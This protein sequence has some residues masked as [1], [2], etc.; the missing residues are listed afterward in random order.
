MG[1]SVTSLPDGRTVMIAGEHEDSYDPDFQIYNDVIVHHPDDTLDIYGYPEDIFPPT[2][3][4]TATLI[5]D[6]IVIIGNLGYSATRRPGITQV[7]ELDLATFAVRIR[8]TTGTPPG[9]LHQHQAV[10]DGDGSRIIV[11]GGLIDPGRDGDPGFLENPDSWSLDLNNWEWTRLTHFPWERYVLYAK[12]LWV[13]PLWNLG[14]LIWEVENGACMG[15]DDGDD[16]DADPQDAVPPEK[17]EEFQSCFGTA[18]PR[19]RKAAAELYSQGFSPELS[20]IKDL[21]HPDIP[22]TEVPAPEINREETV[23]END[24]DSEGL[25]DFD[26][27]EFD[28]VRIQVDGV[29]V[30]YKEGVSTLSLTV[31]GKL[32]PDTVSALLA[33]LIRKLELLINKPIT[34]QKL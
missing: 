30:R 21:F 9:W 31:E 18:N 14:Q 10:L 12:E 28:G 11:K 8:A 17:R 33:D 13:L 7:A 26:E 2:D 4:H 32:P 27:E 22:H 19:A 3:F 5:G 34:V 20:V 16:D 25:Y 6:S 15:S 23:E 1:Q 29:V 24:H